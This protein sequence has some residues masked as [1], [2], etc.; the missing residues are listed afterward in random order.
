ML[1]NTLAL[2]RWQDIIDIILVAVLLYEI[3]KLLR[4]SSAG[5][6]LKG[7]VVIII[8]T[9][10]FGWLQL[11]VLYYLLSKTLQIGILAL[12]ILFQPELRRMLDSLGR[13]RLPSLFIQDRDFNENTLARSIALLVETAVYFSR[14]RTGA[15]IAI[16]RETKLGDIIKT[17]TAI[18]SDISVELLKNI[19]YN[20]APLHDG[21]VVIRDNRITAAGCVLPLSENK[22]LSRELG[23]RHRAGV[24]L[25]E[26]SD[27]IVIIVSEE[28]GSISV[29]SGG[30]LK[31]YLSQEMLSALLTKELIIEK[32]EEKKL[33]KFMFWRKNKD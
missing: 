33:R 21:A 18:N 9:Q 28:T 3:I 27:A 4:D 10:I 30:L 1:N 32:E 8:A 24:G 22:N 6:V 25:S 11:N 2:M 14:T 13:R 29:A 15:L 31:R 5:Q 17:G 26:I 16:E 23:T 7:I 19:F 20:K 12:V